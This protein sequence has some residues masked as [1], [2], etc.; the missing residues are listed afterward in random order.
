MILNM[1][2]AIWASSSTVVI[3]NRAV[4]SSEVT[5]SLAQGIAMRGGAVREPSPRG[6]VEERRDLGAQPH[7]GNISGDDDDGQQDATQQ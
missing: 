2:T 6:V 4:V 5:S 7:G 1:L 3:I